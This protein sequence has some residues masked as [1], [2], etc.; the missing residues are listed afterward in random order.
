[1]PLKK[2]TSKETVSQNISE[3][4]GGKTYGQTK[5]K[6]GKGTADKQA[7]AVALNEQRKS[8]GGMNPT[9]MTIVPEGKVRRVK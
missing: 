5:E 7:V 2:G 9:G 1:M 3:F 6:F 4:H 8:G